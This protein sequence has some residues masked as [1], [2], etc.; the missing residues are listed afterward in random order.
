MKNVFEKS[1]HAD[2]RWNGLGDIEAGRPNLGPDMPVRVYRIFAYA[3]YDVLC[4]DQG[5]EKADEL[6][7]KAGRRAGTELAG[8]LLDLQLDVG[9]FLAE[10]ADQ[11]LALKIGVL[12]IEKMQ[13]DLSEFVVTVG[14]DLDC[15]GL[16]V[17]G[18]AA[19]HYDE[20]FLQGIFESYTDKHYEVR[21]VDC[22]ATGDHV[23]R[24]EGRQVQ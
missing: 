4:H 1:S 3:M 5:K 14:E 11:L 2:F 13:R 16:P 15:S 23:C 18:E 6:V 7:R 17:T 10:L 19:C 21:E 24:F 20:G 22:W 9:H 8:H 12:R